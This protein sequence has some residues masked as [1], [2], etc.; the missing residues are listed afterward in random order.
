MASADVLLPWGLRMKTITFNDNRGYEAFQLAWFAV[1][2][3]VRAGIV[4]L[5]AL[6]LEVQLRRKLE[7]VS[8]ER[9]DG[10]VLA[11]ECSLAFDKDE[12]CFLEECFRN[13]P[14]RSHVLADVWAAAQHFGIDLTKG[15][16]LREGTKR[17][18]THA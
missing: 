4:L 9:A 7:A 10:R 13:T 2:L 14:W 3:H 16:L 6:E 12:L 11:A 18:L 5:P 15:T 17:A 8:V 1:A